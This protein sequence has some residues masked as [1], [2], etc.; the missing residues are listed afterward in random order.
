VPV[1]VCVLLWAREGR[2]DALVAYEDQVL[3]LMHDHGARVVFRGRASES[4]DGPTEIHI[5]TYPSEAA[6][7]AYMQ[8]ERRIAM[9]DQREQAVER[10]EVFRL[11]QV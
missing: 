8:D 11:D 4:S 10:T 7:D 9:A 5:L 3:Q 6:F 2:R 1:T